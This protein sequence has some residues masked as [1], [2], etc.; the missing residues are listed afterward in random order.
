MH[1]VSRQFLLL[2]SRHSLS[3]VIKHTTVF[4]IQSLATGDQTSA[5]VAKDQTLFLSHEDVCIGCPG[6]S[7]PAVRNPSSTFLIPPLCMTS[8]YGPK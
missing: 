2:R 8:T 1:H 7:D 5:G 6:L 3:E 4:G